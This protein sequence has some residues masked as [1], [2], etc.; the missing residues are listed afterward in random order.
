MRTSSIS[1]SSKRAQ[2]YPRKRFFTRQNLDARFRA[3]GRSRSG[4]I[5]CGGGRLFATGGSG[6]VLA[7]AVE[8][9]LVRSQ[10][11]TAG[12]KTG[13]EHPCLGIDQDIIDTVAVFADEVVV[14]LYERIKMLG[15]A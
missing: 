8:R 7:G 13:E 9:K 2:V 14:T 11:E 5:S 1:L 15:A 3:H 10:F 6:A 12:R 4:M